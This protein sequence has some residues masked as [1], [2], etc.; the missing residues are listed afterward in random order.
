MVQETAA[1]PNTREIVIPRQ[2][3]KHLGRSA[4]FIL[5]RIYGLCPGHVFH[6]LSISSCLLLSCSFSFSV[7]ERRAGQLSRERAGQVVLVFWGESSQND[8]VGWKDSSL[9]KHPEP[10]QQD[11]RPT[12]D[13]IPT[14]S[15][16]GWARMMV[17]TTTLH[18]N[19]IRHLQHSAVTS[20]V[21]LAPTPH[22]GS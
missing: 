6:G 18:I 21:S 8:Q 9:R 2:V 11:C 10:L 4:G 13:S 15:Q 12:Q 14:E 20:L 16:A 5:T 19:T 3:V 17:I 1:K 7:A 22:E